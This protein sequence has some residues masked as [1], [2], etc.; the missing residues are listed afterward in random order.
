MSEA[1]FSSLDNEKTNALAAAACAGF[2]SAFAQVVFLRELLALFSGFELAAG[3]FLASWLLWTGLGSRLAA[4][5]HHKLSPGLLLLLLALLL[6]G[7]LLL[8]RAARPIWNIPLGELPGLGLML[9]ICALTPALFCLCSGALFAVC[10]GKNAGGRPLRVYLAEALGSGL[11]GLTL[12]FLLLPFVSSLASVLLISCLLFT[13]AYRLLLTGKQW[14]STILTA[15]LIQLFLIPTVSTRLENLSRAWQWGQSYLAGR[16]TPYQNLVVCGQDEQL[17]LFSDG[18]WLFSIPDPLSTEFAVEPV[19]LLHPHPE[20]VLL[21]GGNPLELPEQVRQHPQIRTVRLVEQDPGIPGLLRQLV[22]FPQKKEAF[23]DLLLADPYAMIRSPG[24]SYDIILLQQ[25]EP[26]NAARNRYYTRDFF[27]AA[28]AKLTPGGL[29]SFTAPGAPEAVGPAQARLLRSLHATLQ[30]VFPMVLA[31]PGDQIRFV[32]SQDSSYAD[33]TIPTLLQRMRQRGISTRFFRAPNVRELFS[34]FKQSYLQ[35]LFSATPEPVLNR[36]FH[37][38]CYLD[39]LLAWARQFNE[40]LYTLLDTLSAASTATLWAT[41]A[42]AG[43]L[44]CLAPLGGRSNPLPLA[45]GSAVAVTGACLMSFQL[46]LLLMFQILAG[47]LYS[48]LALLVAASMAGLALGAWL[49]PQKHPA[50]RALLSV[51]TLLCLLLAAFGPFFSLLHG[52]ETPPSTNALLLICITLALGGG[53]LGGLHF[54]LASR[55]LVE[56]GREAGRLGGRL[57]ALDLIGASAGSLLVSLLLLP[58]YGL[59]PVMFAWALLCAASLAGLVLAGKRQ[60]T[61]HTL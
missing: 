30:A 24:P 3:L 15:L 60:G 32:A 52:M 9:V 10:W 34:P 58:L 39:S 43:L 19:L 11:A 13:L 40:Q 33:I 53:M 17:S 45:T 12:F 42:A 16:E 51:Q 28:A 6:P 36:D 22:P 2:A 25:G 8:L 56:T 27:Q 26:V 7:T 37:P 31:L 61:R 5:C 55:L 23:P 29:F 41:V 18:G 35:S 1:N 44:L 14:R 59:R 4:S 47:S 21:L 57:Y 38:A 48:R 54:G 49:T 20:S 46:L 50:F